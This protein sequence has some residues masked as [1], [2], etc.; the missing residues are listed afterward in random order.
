MKKQIRRFL[1]R[2]VPLRLLAPWVLFRKGR[3]AGLLTEHGWARSLRL[4]EP[5]DADGEPIPWIPYTL[6]DL[7]RD[8]LTKELSVLELGAGS[9]T[10]F[11]MRRVARVTAIEHDARWLAW[12]R[13]RSGP[14]VTLVP[15]DGTTP[16]RYLAP[17]RAPDARY[18]LILIDGI[19]R[20]EALLA[21]FDRLT[22]EGVILLDD[23]HRPELAAALAQVPP[24]FRSLHFTGHKAGSVNLYRTTLLYR[25]GNCLG[26]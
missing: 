15:A 18:D 9:S 6:V 16:E 7:L 1:Y 10:L 17:L 22:R 19:H 24:E 8:R 26:I 21:A 23:T 11:F 5:I 4:M 20:P 25:D 2:F 14:N 13:E 12:V 3:R